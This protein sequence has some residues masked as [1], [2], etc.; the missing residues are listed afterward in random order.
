MASIIML[1]AIVVLVIEKTKLT[2]LRPKINEPKIEKRSSLLTLLSTLF[3][4]LYQTNTKITANTLR[5]R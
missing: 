5:P 2:M 1:I 3:P 4:S